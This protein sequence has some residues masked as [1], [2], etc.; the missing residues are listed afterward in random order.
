M[1]APLVTGIVDTSVSEGGS[2]AQIDLKTEESVI[3]FRADHNVLAELAA[4]FLQMDTYAQNQRHA[5]SGHRG[6]RAV[7]AV[8]GS[9]EP[10]V[11][12]SKV[13]L[14]LV[15]DKGLAYHFALPADDCDLLSNRMRSASARARK[16]ARQTRQ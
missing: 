12:G 3:A 5:T 10:A 6:I 1:T 7:E 15:G 9:A 2:M 8:E 11:G 14:S 4:R 13:I 16:Q